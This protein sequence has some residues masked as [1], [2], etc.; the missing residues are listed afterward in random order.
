MKRRLRFLVLL[1]AKICVV[2]LIDFPVVLQSSFLKTNSKYFCSKFYKQQFVHIQNLCK[3]ARLHEKSKIPIMFKLILN[4]LVNKT[5]FSTL[6]FLLEVVS[7]KLMMFYCRQPFTTTYN[8]YTVWACSNLAISTLQF[9]N[10]KIKQFE[11]VS[12]KKVRLL[13]RINY[14]SALNRLCHP[15]NNNNNI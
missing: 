10:T 14:V 13:V 11:H 12:C 7:C 5:K 6:T 8:D 2:F 1:V 9:D 15:N 3:T 4:F